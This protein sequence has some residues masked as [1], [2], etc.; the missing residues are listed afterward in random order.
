MTMEALEVVGIVELVS[1]RKTKFEQAECRVVVFDDDGIDV[2]EIPN[3]LV[4][5]GDPT[6][7]QNWLRE[8]VLAEE[9]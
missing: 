4:N 6:L 2:S 7:I 1:A 5:L 9:S 8:K 3:E